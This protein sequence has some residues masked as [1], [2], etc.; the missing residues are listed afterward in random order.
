MFIFYILICIISLALQLPISLNVYNQ[1]QDVNLTSP[2]YF[3]HGGRWYVVPDQEIDV[4]AVMSNL[5]E[6]EAGQDI[7]EGALAYRIQRKHVRS[8][9]NE[10][11]CIW[12]LVAWYSERT[13]EPHICALLV[14]HNKKLDEDRLRKLYQK[15]WPS[16]RAQAN[17]TRGSWTL[18]NT[19]KLKTTIKVMNAGCKWQISIS[20]E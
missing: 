12:F 6:P 17:A 20:E 4:S 16:L 10:S 5:I 18:N 14:E 13:R 3:V 19:T 8:A 2:V 15:R 1:C 9:Q 11:K 7:L